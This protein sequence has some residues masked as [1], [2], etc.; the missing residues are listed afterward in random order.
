VCVCVCVCVCA[1]VCVCGPYRISVE[2]FQLRIIEL[3]SRKCYRNFTGGI[4]IQCDEELKLDISF[5]WIRSGVHRSVIFVHR[6]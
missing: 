2:N 3:L 4:A 1:C 5:V 6:V